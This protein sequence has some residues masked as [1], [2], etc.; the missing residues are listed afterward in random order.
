MGL[1]YTSLEKAIVALEKGIE[2][3]NKKNIEVQDEEEIEIIKSGII[4]NFEVAYEIS[5]K[6]MKKWLSENIGTTAVDGI[7]RKELFRIAAQNK[8]IDDIEKWFVFHEARNL[9]SHDYDGIKAE[10]VFIEALAFPQYSRKLE[11][12]LEEKDD[13]NWKR[14]IRN[15]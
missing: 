4:Q 11:E 8:L 10:D 5:W 15:C 14:T 1:N 6:L 9:T 13:S 12:R 3:Y 2:I 7:S